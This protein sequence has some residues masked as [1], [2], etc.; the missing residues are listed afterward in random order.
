[1]F[2]WRI[3]TAFN[4]WDSTKL[5]PEDHYTAKE[6]GVPYYLNA[7]YPLKAVYGVDNTCRAPSGYEIYGQTRIKGACVVPAAAVH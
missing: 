2:L 3:W 4:T 5:P 7:D 1:M 6:A